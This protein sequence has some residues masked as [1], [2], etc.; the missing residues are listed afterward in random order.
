MSKKKKVVAHIHMYEKVKWGANK[1]IIWKCCL[2]DCSHYLHV[3]FILGKKSICFKCGNPFLMTYSKLLRNRPKCDDCQSLSGQG[4]KKR[5]DPVQQVL[6]KSA[7]I[8]KGETTVP[9]LSNINIDD[10]LE[11]L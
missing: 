9:D 6:V 5:R 1:T 2:A 7:P 3:E 4:P 11:N 8:K 10:L